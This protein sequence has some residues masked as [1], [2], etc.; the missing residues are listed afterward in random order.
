MFSSL[1]QNWLLPVLP[2]LKFLSNPNNVS[3]TILHVFVKH[4][5]K[6]WYNLGEFDLSFIYP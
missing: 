3:I 1:A 4:L 5:Y 2:I 6:T